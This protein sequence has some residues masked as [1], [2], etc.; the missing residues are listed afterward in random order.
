MC[1][2][3]MA[4]SSLVIS[5]R[6]T[7][8]PPHHPADLAVRELAV[9][10]LL[11]RRRDSR[12][13]TG[14]RVGTAAERAPRL[15]GRQRADGAQR[16]RPTGWSGFPPPGESSG[17]HQRIGPSGIWSGPHRRETRHLRRVPDP[18][19][20]ARHECARGGARL[21][22]GRRHACETRQESWSSRRRCWSPA[23][24]ARQAARGRRPESHGREAYF[25]RDARPQSDLRDR[26]RRSPLR[27]PPRNPRPHRLPTSRKA[28]RLNA[29]IS[30]TCEC[31]RSRNPRRRRTPHARD[32]HLQPRARGRSA[33]RLPGPPVADRPVRRRPRDVQLGATATAPA[34]SPSRR[35]TDY[36]RW[37]SPRAGS[38]G[39]WADA[40]DPP[41]C[42]RAWREGVVHPR[43]VMAEGRA[44]TRG[45]AR[46]RSRSR[47]SSTAPA[48]STCPPDLAGRQ[49][50]CTAEQR[51]FVLL[52]E[53]Q[54]SI[55]SHRRAPGLHPRRVPP[56]LPATT[57]WSALPDGA[58]L[59]RERG[60][61]AATRR[62]AR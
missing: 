41:P 6:A 21:E 35:P 8:L 55:P 59:V 28:S 57:V 33:H 47:A 34:R 48:S 39:Q 12:S 24:I 25:D 27:R 58:A 45:P 31:H 52:I 40:A 14:S 36:D 43:I 38:S 22:T 19:L 44:A 3:I 62:P 15:Q 9:W 5:P 17:I 61:H 53:R 16:R 54:S 4:L 13:R 2:L 23:A 42:A 46:G 32:V 10:L 49:A 29:V 20:P 56:R 7:A 11:F 1:W 30:T 18:A 51:P 60:A 26:H 50:R 37:L